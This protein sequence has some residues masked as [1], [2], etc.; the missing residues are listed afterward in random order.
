[1]SWEPPLRPDWVLAVNRGDVP[2]IADA[3]ARPIEPEALLDEARATLGLDR[4][5]GVG[6]IDGDDRFLVPL[7]VA[8]AALEEEARLTV[9]GRWMTRRFLLRLLEVRF[10]LAAYLHEDPGVRD[11]EVRRPVIVTGAMLSKPCPRSQ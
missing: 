10:Q 9:L 6:A 11:E 2:V 4:R 7:G 3:A 1:M 5:A 8:C